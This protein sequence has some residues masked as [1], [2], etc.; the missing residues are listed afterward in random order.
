MP[1][2]GADAARGARRSGA[3]RR[4]PTSPTSRSR[5]RPIARLEELRLAA[6]EERIEADLA[7]GRHAELVGELE[8]LVARAS[9]ARAAA[10]PADARAL[11]RRA[12]GRGARALPGRPAARS[13][14]SSGSTRARRCRRSSGRS[15]VRI[16]SSSSSPVLQPT[17][18]SA[19]RRSAAPPAESGR[20]ILVVPRADEE[21]DALVTVR[22]ARSPAPR[23]GTGSSSSGSWRPGDDLGGGRERP[24]GAAYGARGRAAPT[25]AR[26]PSRRATTP[27]T[28]CGWPPSR[29]STCSCSTGRSRP[30][31]PFDDELRRRPRAGALRRRA[32]RR[33]RSAAGAR[34]RAGAGAQCPSAGNEHEWAALE[35]GAWARARSGRR[36]GC[37]ARA[38]TPTRERRDA[39]RLLASAALAVQQ[40]AGVV[41]E[42]VLV[43]AGRGGRQRGRT[44]RCARR[45]RLLVALAPG[46]N[47]ACPSAPWPSRPTRRCSSFDVAFGREGC[48]R[49]RA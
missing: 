8:A 25:F 19:S 23:S 12:A 32:S 45:A 34:R 42:P 3:A 9:A 47:R 10:R 40:L 11:P 39:S 46:G 13:S 33:C 41:T 37:S 48:R 29:M 1:R 18:T 31:E 16:P 38:R 35:V 14:T 27:T 26:R 22:C 44:R 17:A 49:R 15:C 2:R 7:L 21:L 6:L 4:S 5:R 36:C 43:D 28:S 30:D 24:A 20:A